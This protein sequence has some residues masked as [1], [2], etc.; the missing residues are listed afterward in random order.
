MKI[1]HP[2]LVT[3]AGFGAAWLVRLWLRTLRYQYRPLGPDVRPDRVGSRR[4][5][6]AIWHENMLLLA[7]RYARPDVRVLISRHADGQIIAEVCRRLGF[8]L[9]RGSTTR[10][11]VE[12]VRQMLRLG[13]EAHLGITPD[14]PRGPRRRAQPGVVYLAARTGLP[15]VPVGVGYRRPW[16]ARS[17]DRFALPRPWSAA[18]CVTGEPIPVPPDADRD[19]L[20]TYRRRGE[21]ALRDA[22]ERAERWAETGTWPAEP[23]AA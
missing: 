15:V 1:R 19:R 4:Y 2:A 23:L 3:A 14:G 21:E 20:E 18:T 10:N 12:A 5:I 17:W 22:S 11:G 8:G 7:Q 6:Y 9:V 16:R 13:G